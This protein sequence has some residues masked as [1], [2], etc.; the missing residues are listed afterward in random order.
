[1]AILSWSN[2]KIEMQS[3]YLLAAYHIQY[4]KTFDMNSTIRG[5]GI[6]NKSIV[7]VVEE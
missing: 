7:G 1:M 3:S 5:V 6:T 2:T 4:N